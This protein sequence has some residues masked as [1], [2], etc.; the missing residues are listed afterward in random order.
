MPIT[1]FYASLLAIL[2]LVL[3]ARVIG[4]RREH[5]VELGDAND[6]QLLRRMRVHANFAEYVPFAL[7]LMAL[8]ESMTPPRPILHLVGIM[9]VI[10]RLIHAY[11]LAQSPQILRLRVGGMMLTLIAIGIAAAMCL[12]FSLIYLVA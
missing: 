8:T 3:A 6:P 9:L 11:G 12:W 2:Y 7:L 4:W 10:G 5:R 1:A